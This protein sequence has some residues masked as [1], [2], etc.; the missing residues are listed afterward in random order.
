MR[1]AGGACGAPAENPSP[2]STSPSSTSASPPVSPS[3]TWHRAAAAAEAW[4]SQEAKLRNSGQ[5]QG[6]GQGQAQGNGQG[7]P[8][9]A[10]GQG[11]GSKERFLL[12]RGDVLLM[13]GD[14]CC[15]SGQGEWQGQLVP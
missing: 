10:Q 9:K 3:E 7:P 6:N 15:E 5:S 14:L 1:G 2:S 12:P 8:G 13:G 11:R 4:W